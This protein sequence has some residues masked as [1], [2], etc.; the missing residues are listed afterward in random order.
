MSQTALVLKPEMERSRLIQRLNKPAPPTPFAFGGGLP[1]GGLPE[2]AAKTI[3]AIFSFDYMGAAEFEYG[4]VPAALQFIAVQA[5]KRKIVAGKIGDIYY[6]CPKS[7]KNGVLDII[8]RLLADES[9]L[10][11]N[12]HCGLADHFNKNA[13]YHRGTLGWLELDNGFMFFVDQEMFEKTKSLFG[14]K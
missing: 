9:T 3:S 8:V 10:R 6:L 1:N 7:Y 13:P 14:I 4:A 5:R 2:Q 11:L 12:E